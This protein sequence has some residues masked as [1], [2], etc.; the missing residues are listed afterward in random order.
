MKKISL[1]FTGILFTTVLFAQLNFEKKFYAND[2]YSTNRLVKSENDN[3][4]GY[5]DNE[6]GTHA[7]FY[8]FDS[9][10]KNTV[11]K[12][13]FEP[14]PYHIGFYDNKNET[15]HLYGDQGRIY[16]QIYSEDDKKVNKVKTKFL[17][18]GILKGNIYYSI[19]PSTIASLGSGKSWFSGSKVDI[20][21]ETIEKEFEDKE[22]K[23]KMTDYL[24]CKLF[25]LNNGNLL[26][27]LKERLGKES[28]VSPRPDGF[29]VQLYDDNLNLIS[30]KSE[31]NE[32]WYSTYAGL[33]LV[34]NS[35]PD[36]DNLLLWARDVKT[37]KMTIFNINVKSNKIE[38]TENKIKD[39]DITTSYLDENMNKEGYDDIF[40]FLVTNMPED[41]YQENPGESYFL[42]SAY[43]LG[44]KT[45]V[46]YH[47]HQNIKG[48][49]SGEIF[50]TGI[51]VLNEDGLLTENLAV[52]MSFKDV[53]TKKDET[54]LDNGVQLLY[55][56]Y[57]NNKIVYVYTQNLK[58]KG[59]VIEAGKEVIT[60]EDIEIDLPKEAR[61]NNPWESFSIIP[62][63]HNSFVLQAKHRK[64]YPDG[65]FVY[66]KSNYTFYTIE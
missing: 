58:L 36:E 4:Y 29:T 39:K 26:L 59:F 6:A 3:Y 62:M 12:A 61:P 1:L 42:D 65:T 7:Y 43:T 57:S 56:F 8:I 11:R 34:R 63:S 19:N 18:D 64:P 27:F 15:V 52:D 46:N 38:I 5:S 10:L 25:Q 66:K 24:D 40:K 16:K 31:K 20:V 23:H 45:Y 28:S 22:N 44:D 48:K 35:K 53:K 41:K 17:A 55:P 37:N 21:N 54:P 47:L 14:Y 49:V 33:E 51:F 60:L 9:D 13:I 2:E 32:I 50:M 30:S